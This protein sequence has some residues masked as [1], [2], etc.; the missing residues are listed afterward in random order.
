ALPVLPLLLLVVSVASQR[1]ATRTAMMR[2]LAAA[3]VV[4]LGLQMAGHA[5]HGLNYAKY[6][7]S[8]E[9]R[10]GFLRRNV[11]NYDA[12]PMINASLGENDKLYLIAR[13]VNYLLDVP[14]YYAS[15]TQEGWVDIRPEADDADLFLKQITGRGVSHLL[16]GGDNPALGPTTGP[17]LWR[18]LLRRGC[19]R[20]V[21]TVKARGIGSRTLALSV[22]NTV[23][24][25][26]I[27][28]PDC[29]R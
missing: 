4:T 18:G 1:W 21:G 12:V 26:K 7:F 28:D 3:I 19:L 6:A 15:V 10:D 29:A 25:L 22:E 11:Y 23:N 2:P 17:S 13:Q 9:S 8:D 14:Y 16:V 24:I 20:V 27:T 5:L